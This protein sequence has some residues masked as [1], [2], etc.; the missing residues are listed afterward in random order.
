MDGKQCLGCR[1]RS[2]HH[3]YLPL[4]NDDHWICD[5]SDFN[6]FHID[7]AAT[8][9]APFHETMMKVKVPDGLNEICDYEADT[10]V[11]KQFTEYITR[12]YN[13]APKHAFEVSVK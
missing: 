9:L 11:Y 1:K 7:E 10:M 8:D 6:Q 12:T 5:G 13:M 3:R 2:I 4:L